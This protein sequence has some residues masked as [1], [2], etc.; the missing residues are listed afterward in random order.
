M[1]PKLILGSSILGPLAVI[2]SYQKQGIGGKLI[3]QGLRDPW[4]P[5]CRLGLC[6][7][8]A[9]YYPKYGFSSRPEQGFEPPY[10]ILPEEYTD[11][12]MSMTLHPTAGV[13]LPGTGEH[14]PADT[15]DD[16]DTGG[17]RKRLVHGN[18]FIGIIWSPNDDPLRL[19]FFSLWLVR[20]V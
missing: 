10:S 11:A 16:P 13:K 17:N 20:I 12:W 8:H 5:R 6:L 2:P 1:D 18:D 9:S 7:G 19:T 4:K 3:K 15:F 14:C